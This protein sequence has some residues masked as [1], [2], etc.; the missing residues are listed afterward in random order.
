MLWQVLLIYAAIA[1]WAVVVLY[2][3][4]PWWHS[5]AGVNIML[6]SLGCALAFTLLAVG[7]DGTWRAAVWRALVGLLG[8]ALTHRAVLVCVGIHRDH[9]ARA[10]Q[11]GA[12]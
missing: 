8:L 4:R 3:T 9:L 1:G 2:S 7:G 6:L 5:A 11:G 12:R 10:A